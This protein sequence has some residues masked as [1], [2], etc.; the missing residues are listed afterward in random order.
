M[1]TAATPAALS[2]AEE[3]ALLAR[4]RAGDREALEALLARVAPSIYRF[5]LRMCRNV[6]DAEDVLQDALLEVAGHVGDFEGRSSLS[7]WVFAVT[8]SACARKRRGL[9]NQAFASVSDDARPEEVDQLARRVHHVELVRLGEGDGEAL[10]DIDE[11]GVGK[12]AADDGA[13]HP[14]GRG[15]IR[16]QA[17]E[18]GADQVAAH[19][20]PEHLADLALGEELVSLHFDARDPEAVGYGESFS[21]EVGAHERGADRGADLDEDGRPPQA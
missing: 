4:V 8:R 19:R 16:A 5:G 20:G 1:P 21:E 12:L 6:H 18:V 14:G 2:S 7:S 9:K 17:F 10:R 3:S 15:E 13:S 11:Q